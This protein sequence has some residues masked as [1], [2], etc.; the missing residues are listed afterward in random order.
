MTT[1]LTAVLLAVLIFGSCDGGL[2]PPGAPDAGFGGTIRF[3][4]AS[5]P[6]ADSIYGLW[7]F[8]SQNA[9]T[10][11][12][13]IFSG[14]FSNPPTIYLYPGLTGSL[15]LLPADS[16]AYV[17]KPIPGTYVYTGVIQQTEPAISARALRIVGLFTKPGP[18]FVPDTIRIAAG[19]FMSGIDIAV[20][21]D[22]VPPQ[23]F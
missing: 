13:A 17:I 14:L 21:F 5:W 23:P 20:D 22:N 4:R 16:L 10:D 19:E 8:T 11:S 9:L 1:R 15:D 7:V 2:E 18:G 6:P 3:V 12:S